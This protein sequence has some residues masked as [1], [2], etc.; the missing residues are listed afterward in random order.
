MG[1]AFAARLLNGGFAVLGY[2]IDA[3]R[4]AELEGAGGERAPAVEEIFRRCDRVILSLPSHCE[5]GRVIAEGDPALRPRQIIID[6]TTGDPGHAELLAVE[7]GGR[8]VSYL[9]ATI[10]GNS[11]QVRAGTAVVMIGGDDTAFASCA[12]IF[13]MLGAESF[14]TGLSGTGAKMK[15]VTNLVLGLNRAAL[16]EGLALGEAIGLDAELTLR[17]MRHSPAYSR[18]MD[19]KGEKMIHSE[20]SPDARLSQHLKDV[21]LILELGAAAGL[22]MTLSTAHRAVLEE[23]EA[24]GLGAL[25]NSAL[26]QVLRGVTA[27]EN[28]LGPRASRPHSDSSGPEARGPRKGVES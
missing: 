19:V 18:I 20:F 11:A 9:D 21:R 27:R 26:I 17:V 16:A 3:S 22:P 1:G 12:D 10:S 25:D 23:A 13:A 24:A 7:L 6:T 15:L 28:L 14:H 4:C 5:V 2:D 8:G